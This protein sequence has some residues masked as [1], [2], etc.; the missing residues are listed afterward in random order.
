M[1]ID[2]DTI[3]HVP[4]NY[5]VIDIETTGFSP[6]N[7]SILEIAA[8]KFHNSFE[9]ERFCQL[10]KPDCEL[11]EAACKVNGITYE[12]LSD[13]SDVEQVLRDFI[14]FVGI[15]TII[16]HN[17]AF[18]ISFLQEKMSPFH[19]VL[20]NPVIDTLEMSRHRLPELSSHSLEFLKN[21]FCINSGTAHRALPDVIATAEIFERLCALPVSDARPKQKRSTYARNKIDLSEIVPESVTIDTSHPLYR[22]QIVFTGDMSLPRRELAQIAVNCGAIVK[23]GVSGKTDFLV[24]GQQDIALVG[25]DGL[26]TKQEKAL[27]LNSSGRANIVFLTECEFMG[28]ARGKEELIHGAT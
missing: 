13:A 5:I 9:V 23:S 14:E 3:D 18:D 25:T 22:K 8:A 2:T 17:A 16:A 6:C 1:F 27:H 4:S 10:V 24:V 7:D 20:D 12:M 19:M 28:M 15:Y 26:S 11:S 21:Y